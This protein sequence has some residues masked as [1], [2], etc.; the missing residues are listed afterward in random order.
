M[1]RAPPPLKNHKNIGFLSIRSG[2]DPLE[3][4]SQNTSSYNTG[5]TN[6]VKQLALSS[7]SR[8]LQSKKGHIVMHNKTRTK[9]RTP[10][11]QRKE[12]YIMNQQQ[13]SHRLRKINSLTKPENLNAFYLRQ[14]FALDSVAF[15]HNACLA[16][17]VPS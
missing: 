12:H 8:L 3:E 17:I 11:N 7:S 16:R 2:P 15:K 1:S 5:K 14:I 9:H 10:T 13:H 4:E 6:K